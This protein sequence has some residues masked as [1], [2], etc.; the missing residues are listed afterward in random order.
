LK[1]KGTVA[2]IWHLDRSQDT[3]FWQAS[4]VI[5]DRYFPTQPKAN[6]LK[7][8]SYK[9]VSHYL[10]ENSN[11]CGLDL[12]FF[13]WEKQYSKADFLGLLSTFSGHMTLAENKRKAFFREIAA[14]IDRFGGTV[15]RK[16]ESMFVFA[17]KTA[18]L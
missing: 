2:L 7:P 10:A 13:P 5:Y 11:W 18:E 8:E 1:Y 6:S 15:L 17:R 16:Y 14:L 3:A 12:Q 9:L 4:S